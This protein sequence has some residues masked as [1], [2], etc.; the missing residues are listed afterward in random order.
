MSGSLVC[1]GSLVAI[2]GGWAPGGEEVA[3]RPPPVLRPGRFAAFGLPA[4][5]RPESGWAVT[6]DGVVARS[7]APGPRLLLL[8]PEE[9]LPVTVRTEGSSWRGE[10][11]AR[12]VGRGGTLVGIVGGGALVE[13]VRR[14]LPPGVEVASLEPA[15]TGERWEAL[16][17]FDALVDLDESLLATPAGRAWL[18]MGGAGLGRHPFRGGLG[19]VDVRSEGAGADSIRDWIRA[20]AAGTALVRLL[21][22]A[23]LA[24][25]FGPPEAPPDAWVR[26]CI[27]LV[28]GVGA[29]VIVTRRR[30][31]SDRSRFLLA[32]GIATA[33][34]L[35]LSRLDLEGPG[36]RVR[37]ITVL[38]QEG[39]VEVPAV[40]V[41]ELSSSV[42]GT[43]AAEWPGQTGLRPLVARG[44]GYEVVCTGTTTRLRSDL[45]R[46]GARAFLVTYPGPAPVPRGPPSWQ[47][48]LRAPESTAP[49]GGP[50]SR[51][52]AALVREGLLADRAEESRVEGWEGAQAFLRVRL[53]R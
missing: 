16:E 11:K 48:S 3:F 8:A 14:G 22:R 32:A 4:E 31:A 20:R 13:E 10:V 12:R 37:T 46:G 30:H 17:A 52:L 19:R 40:S 53:S 2:L 23:A 27:V 6:C 44:G 26:A 43:V 28:L 9:G 25:A 21:E 42:G 51:L 1:W 34:S 33:G 50:A 18:L 29:I 15:E 49:A 5:G 36:G 47:L 41:A 35:V 7:E 39:D 45:V 24:R 38:V